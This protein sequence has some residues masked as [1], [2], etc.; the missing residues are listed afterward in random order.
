MTVIGG[1]PVKSLGVNS[2]R[3]RSADWRPFTPSQEN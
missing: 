2:G 1:A 3:A